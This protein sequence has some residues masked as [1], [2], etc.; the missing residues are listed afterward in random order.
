MK[1]H[2]YSAVLSD[3]RAKE[4]KLWNVSTSKP[5][6]AIRC[7]WHRDGL[8]GKMS[9]RYQN[10]DSAHRHLYTHTHHTLTHTNS[11]T[12]THTHTD[13]GQPE[14][15]F[16]P[17]WPCRTLYSSPAPSNFGAAN[18]LQYRRATHRPAANPIAIPAYIAFPTR[19][20]M[21][22]IFQ[23]WQEFSGFVRYKQ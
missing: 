13:L 9:W 6:I 20:R 19:S 5:R 12:H 4:L 8:F 18:F 11:H 16:E 1:I 2:Q 3:S 21:L 17:M 15:Q 23:I 14:F 7:R 10:T 22:Y